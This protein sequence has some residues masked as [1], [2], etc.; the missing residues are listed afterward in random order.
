M[1]AADGVQ[2]SARI[3][4]AGDGWPGCEVARSPTIGPPNSNS[5]NMI[6]LSNLTCRLTPRLLSPRT[7]GSLSR[8]SLVAIALACA[9]PLSAQLAPALPRSTPERQGISS[10]AILSFVQAADTG[11]D[12]MHSFMLVRHGNV[13]AE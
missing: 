10:A 13:V 8:S 9:A 6:D 12:A 1:A 4:C 3:L 2:R 5:R 7:R 11:F